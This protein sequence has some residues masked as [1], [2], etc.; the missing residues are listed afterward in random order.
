MKDEAKL[1]YGATIC[2]STDDSKY[3][4]LLHSNIPISFVDKKLAYNEY[5]LIRSVSNIIGTRGAT[6][7]E[8]LDKIVRD[9]V[10]PHLNRQCGNPQL[11]VKMD[12]KTIG[13]Q[14]A[15][16]KADVYSVQ[17]FAV[18]IPVENLKGSSDEK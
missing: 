16:R 1:W 18:L 3:S 5:D 10:T 6:S 9:F 14:D 11:Y 13:I 2:Y 15:F 12:G 7:F 17:I 8:Q 4:N